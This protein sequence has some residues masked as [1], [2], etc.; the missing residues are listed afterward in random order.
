MLKSMG[1]QIIKYDR[2]TE[3]QQINGIIQYSRQIIFF[4]IYLTGVSELKWTKS[5]ALSSHFVLLA[6][7]DG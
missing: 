3:Q 1:M 7:L 2:A 6:G 4:F 5:F